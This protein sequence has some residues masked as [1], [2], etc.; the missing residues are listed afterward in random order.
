MYVL[1]PHEFSRTRAAISL[2]L[3][4]LPIGSAPLVEGTFSTKAPSR[5]CALC[6]QS[7]SLYRLW[8]SYITD[9]QPSGHHRHRLRVIPRQFPS[10]GFAR[11]ASKRFWGHCTFSWNEFRI[12]WSCFRITALFPR[13]W[14]AAST[15]R[16]PTR[17]LTTC[18]NA[19]LNIWD[20]QRIR[21]S[22]VR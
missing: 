6:M 12:P 10:E 22:L 13:T 1:S 3:H 9:C 4:R 21:N 5:P 8:H 11:P 17:L 7:E 16:G 14:T 2:F 19:I 18:Q 15:S 20:I